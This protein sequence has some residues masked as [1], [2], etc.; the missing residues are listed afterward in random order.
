MIILIVSGLKV[1]IM[2]S[3][4]EHKEL[5][6]YENRHHYQIKI[7][8]HLRM[9]FKKTPKGYYYIDGKRVSKDK[10][11]YQE[12]Y[13]S[14]YGKPASCLYTDSKGNQYKSH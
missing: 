10:Y 13:Q 9:Q 1:C 4:E 2:E 6:K 11:E 3:I 12:I 7:R 5:L 8:S 14:M